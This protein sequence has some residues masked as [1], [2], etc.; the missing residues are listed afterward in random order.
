MKKLISII[1]SV[2]LLFSILA[3]EASAALPIIKEKDSSG[4]ETSAIDY[5]ATVLQYLSDKNIFCY[6]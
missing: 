5:K 4:S 6:G 2:V 1:L 3:V